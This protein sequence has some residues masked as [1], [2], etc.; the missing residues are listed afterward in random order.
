RGAH[1]G[2]W[3]FMLRRVLGRPVLFA[4]ASAAILLGLA[5]PALGMH[6]QTLSLGQLLPWNSAQASASRQIAAEFPG[7]PAPAEIVVKSRDIQAPQVRRAIAS[8]QT[9]PRHAPARH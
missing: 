5:A 1:G 6:T 7:G 9:A 2:V 8:L 4:A 3:D